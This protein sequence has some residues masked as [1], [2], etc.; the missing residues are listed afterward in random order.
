MSILHH[1]DMTFFMP[2]IKHFFEEGELTRESTIAHF[3]TVEKMTF[4][5][6]R[7]FLLIS[8]RTPAET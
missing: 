1:Y 8:I 4:I 5:L 6:I 7:A 3:A 2:H